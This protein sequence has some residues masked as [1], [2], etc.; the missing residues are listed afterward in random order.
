MINKKALTLSIVIPVYNEENYLK[1]CLDSIASQHVHA[2]QVIVVDNNSTDR[3]VAV[4]AAYD[5]VTVLSEPRQHQAYAQ[6]TGFNHVESD[7]IARIDADTI[8]DPNWVKAAKVY[9]SANPQAVAVTG[10]AG[11]YDVPLKKV[12][13][14][15]FHFYHYVAAS[16]IAGHGMLWGANCA[17]RSSAWPALKKQLTARQ[18]LWEDY[19]LSFNLAKYGRLDFYPAIKAACS[20]RS[21]HKDVA[22]LVRYQLRGIRT[23][24]MHV[25]GFRFVLFLLCWS[26]MIVFVPLALLDHFILSY[27]RFI[28]SPR[29]TL[30]HYIDSKASREPAKIS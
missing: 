5:F 30:P 29:F 15:L 27:L 11:F 25:S 3:S 23:F 13:Q 12:A 18:D 16:K 7:I 22:Q 8:L 21:A 17:F 10:Y 2:D 20:F 19:D 26:S 6:I 1:A 9:F 14:N 28:N 4:A 24:K